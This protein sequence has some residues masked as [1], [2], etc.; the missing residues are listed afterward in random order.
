MKKLFSLFALAGLLSIG[1][2]SCIFVVRDS[3]D[4]HSREI[5]SSCGEWYGS[6]DC[7]DD[8]AALCGHCGKI[9]G[10]PGCCK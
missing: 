2:S 8:D 5:C 6:A 7:C 3:D 9:E 1:L 10:S 4:H